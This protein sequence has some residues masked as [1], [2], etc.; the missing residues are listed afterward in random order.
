MMRHRQAAVDGY[1]NRPSCRIVR[2]RPSPLQ[3]VRAGA[4]ALLVVL[5]V[6][7][8]VALL[9]L[10]AAGSAR[11]AGV[12]GDWQE[13]AGC[14]AVVAG[15]GVGLAGVGG[16]HGPRAVSK[17]DISYTASV[18]ICES[19]WIYKRHP[20]SRFLFSLKNFQKN[21]AFAGGHVEDCFSLTSLHRQASFFISGVK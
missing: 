3:P 13:L 9:L 16:G 10:V 6:V 11:A 17:A 4:V 1:A 7:A 20:P 8:F 18:S 19:F 14:H 5:L 2:V 15:G 21:L 12:S